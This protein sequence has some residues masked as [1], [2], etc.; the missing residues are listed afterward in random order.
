MLILFTFG[1]TFVALESHGASFCSAPEITLQV[2]TVNST[3][4]DTTAP[5]HSESQGCHCAH[6]ANC[7][8]VVGSEGS[9]NVF[10]PVALNRFVFT[11]ESNLIVIDGLIKPPRA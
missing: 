6:S 7:S 1:V 11:D 10:L 5:T 3:A 8:L 4:T 2:S 9:P